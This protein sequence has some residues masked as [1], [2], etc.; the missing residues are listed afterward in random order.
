MTKKQSIEIR[1]SKLEEVI[2]IL[3][4]R[5]DQ[6]DLLINALTLIIQC[7]QAEIAELRETLKATN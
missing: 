6:Q 3:T 2:S 7:L 4:E 1:I 5:V